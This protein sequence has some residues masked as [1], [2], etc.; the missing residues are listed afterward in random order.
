MKKIVTQLTAFLL[1]SLNPQ[2][3]KKLLNRFSADDSVKKYQQVLSDYEQNYNPA[4]GGWKNTDTNEIDYSSI[5]LE[6]GKV[7]HT[8]IKLLKPT[9]ILET[10]VHKGYSTCCMASALYE[11]KTN[12]HIW[13][14]DPQVLPHL[15]ENTELDQ[16]VTWIPKFSNETFEDVKNINFDLLVLDSNHDYNTAIWELTTFEPLLKKGGYIFMHDTLYFDGVG[17]A[18]KQLYENPRFELV[19]LDSPRTHGHSGR[20]PGIT[21][22]RKIKN[23][24]PLFFEE[25]YDQWFI[26]E[27]DKEAF[28][29]NYLLE[30]A[31][32]TT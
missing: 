27:P 3:K 2:E 21:I 7:W 29:R 24:A 9:S 10:G 20:C 19:T 14:I 26:G 6:V 25:E 22:I 30:M 8:L 11:L 28:L 5:E 12:G 18:V 17:A 31:P 1:N 23:G 13:C 15:W 32:V 4:T 16:L